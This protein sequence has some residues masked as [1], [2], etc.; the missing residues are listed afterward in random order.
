MRTLAWAVVTG[1]VSCGVLRT[2]VGGSMR[3]Q[4]VCEQQQSQQ[5][6][7]IVLGLCGDCLG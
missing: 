4:G 6:P 5:R 3:G 2:A 7:S 1:E